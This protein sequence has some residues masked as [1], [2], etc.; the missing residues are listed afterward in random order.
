MSD[1]RLRFLAGTADD[2]LA[3]VA[4]LLDAPTIRITG[5]VR[6]HVLLLVL[7][8]LLGRVFPRLDV[9]IDPTAPA[10][11]GLPPGAPTIG[12]RVEAVRRRSPLPPVPPAAP[13]LTVHVGGGSPPADLYVDASEW[14]SYL[15]QT[16]SRLAAPRRDSAVGAMTAACRAGARVLALLLAPLRAAPALADTYASA[17]TYRTGTD[18]LADPVPPSIGTLDDLLAGAGSVGGAAVYTMAFEP[19]L[20]GSLVVCDP[21]HL[22][23]TNPYRSILATADAASQTVAKAT[24]ARDA[25][26]HHTLL[27]VDPHVRTVADWEAAQPAQPRLPVVLVAVDS[28][29]A[30]EAIQDSLPLEVV[31]AAAAPDL[32]AVS[33]HRTGTGPCMC[34][35]HMAEVLD[36]HT[37]RNRLIAAQTGIDQRIVNELRVQARP[38]DEHTLRQ[39]E[40]HRGLRTGALDLYRGRTLDD[41]NAAEL[42]YGE[43]VVETSS[44]TRVAVASP[45]V[46]A[47]A[48]ALLA[49]EAFK[50][51]TPD[52]AS[53]ALG[54]TGPGIQYRENPETPKHGYLDSVTARAPACLCRSVRRLRI[55]AELHGLDLA[56]L[57]A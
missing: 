21:Q 25:L 12:E 34:C 40:G 13:T 53:Y 24:E 2:A 6:H 44:G 27:R 15:G 56:D 41:L 7:V 8:D 23:A 26:A 57:T 37:I 48:G 18:P 10:V 16:P 46:T 39:I 28:R 35:L 30:R 43:S 14:Q 45:F 36:G 33:G 20:A 38:L 29:E 32:V 1:P 4:D 49:G 3:R 11:A 5:D 55:L 54:P 17:L 50:R 9:A 19:D 51:A 47:L 42:L 52:L 31:N 22:E